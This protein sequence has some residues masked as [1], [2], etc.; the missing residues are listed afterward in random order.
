MPVRTL[1]KRAGGARVLACFAVVAGL[2]G[3][4][5]RVVR[6]QGISMEP[7]FRNQQWLLVRPLNWPTPPLRK[8]DV[9]VFDQDGKTLVKRVV[10]LGG[11][12]LPPEAPRDR[13][14]P[15]VPLGR[16]YVMGDNREHSEDSRDFGPIAVRSVIGRVLRWSDPGRTASH[17]AG[18]IKTSAR[19][20]P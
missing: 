2:Y 10:A 4:A 16:L 17:P 12:P 20:A 5:F 19:P 15:S 18:G 6:V 1:P 14:H 9:I 7:T 11:E 13:K 3:Y 8:D